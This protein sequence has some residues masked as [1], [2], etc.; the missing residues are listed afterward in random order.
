MLPNQKKVLLEHIRILVVDDDD[1]L[2]EI[3]A[4]SLEGYGAH[5]LQASSGMKACRVLE[6]DSFDVVLSDMRMPDGDGLFLAKFV[7]N[8]Q[9]PKPVF[10][11]HSGFH[12]L[13]PELCA[14]AEIAE[15]IVKP[16]KIEDIALKIKD[17]LS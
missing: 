7:Q 9:K 6:K 2:R 14:S 15:V 11:I 10:L 3:I 13:T 4:E 1:D 17:H 5:V 8:R 16:S 12:D